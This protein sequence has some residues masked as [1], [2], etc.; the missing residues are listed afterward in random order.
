MLQAFEN[1]G[2]GGVIRREPKSYAK[3]LSWG[4]S[5]PICLVYA[6]YTVPV[7]LIKLTNNA[8]SHSLHDASFVKL[9]NFL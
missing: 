5:L 4:L 7:F 6:P 8:P 3:M 1:P 9:N 2:G